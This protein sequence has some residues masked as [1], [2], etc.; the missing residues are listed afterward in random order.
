M[1]GFLLVAQVEADRLAR[2]SDKNRA[3]IGG[4]MRK[5]TFNRPMAPDR[6]EAAADCL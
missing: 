1:R 5:M 2:S 3:Y 6:G 4:V